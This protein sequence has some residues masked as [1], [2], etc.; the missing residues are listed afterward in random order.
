[1]L[2]CLQTHCVWYDFG[3]DARVMTLWYFLQ[4]IIEICCL[5]IK[6]CA[7]MVLFDR[8][9]GGGNTG[10]SWHGMNSYGKRTRG[11]DHI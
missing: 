5:E 8:D 7:R 2:K 11:Q 3:M 1:M 9:E 4:G 6:K 10:T